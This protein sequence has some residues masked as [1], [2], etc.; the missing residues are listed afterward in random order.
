MQ[1]GQEEDAE[2]GEDPPAGMRWGGKGD[3]E[4]WFAFFLQTFKISYMSIIKTNALVFEL[5][6]ESLTWW[7][8]TQRHRER[9]WKE[10]FT[11][12][13]ESIS[14]RLRTNRKLQH[15]FCWSSVFP[16]TDGDQFF[17]FFKITQLY[18]RFFGIAPQTIV[19]KFIIVTIVLQSTFIKQMK[20][21]HSEEK[22]KVCQSNITCIV[23][24][25]NISLVNPSKPYSRLDIFSLYILYAL[26]F[27]GVDPGGT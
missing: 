23:L 5:E 7:N 18:G 22:E 13:R 21:L 12:V 27:L 15:T 26:T 4:L 24:C 17:F 3:F 16:N 19:K 11:N 6:T 8:V 9:E 20:I 10:C 14:Y 2:C 1:R 25:L